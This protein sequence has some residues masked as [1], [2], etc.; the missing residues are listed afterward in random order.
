VYAGSGGNILQVA[1]TPQTTNNA[2]F[3]NS[4]AS[5]MGNLYPI[6][7]LPAIGS[8]WIGDGGNDMCVPILQ[9]VL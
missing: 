1:Q 7:E 9:R 6:S 8:N 5:W 4:V 2:C 3:A